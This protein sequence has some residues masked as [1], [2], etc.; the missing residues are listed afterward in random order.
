MDDSELVAI[1]GDAQKKKA[2]ASKP[3]GAAL[4]AAALDNLR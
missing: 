3:A 4:A 2:P 1:K